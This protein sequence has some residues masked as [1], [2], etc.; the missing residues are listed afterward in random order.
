M[1]LL[2]DPFTD[3]A[4]S[5]S[6]LSDAINLTPIQ[7]GRI[8]QLGVFTEKGVRTRNVTI[9]RQHNYLVL[10]PTRPPGAPSSSNA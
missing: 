1:A 2:N 10:L 7:W 5:M 4:F 9:E 3:P 8:Q 6:E